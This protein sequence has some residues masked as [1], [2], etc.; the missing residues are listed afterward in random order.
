MFR[1]LPVALLVIGLLLGPAPAQPIAPEKK[2]DKKPDPLPPGTVVAVYESLAEALKRV[3][4]AILLTP[5]Q[6][7]QL[8]DEIDRLKKQNETPKPRVPSKC[9]ITGKIEGNLALLTVRFEFDTEQPGTPVR[10]GFGQGSA[11]G[12]RLGGRT[13]SLVNDTSKA[14]NGFIVE[15]DRAGDHTLDLDLVVPLTPR[16][17]GIGLLVDLPRAAITSLELTLPPNSRDV[18]LAGKSAAEARLNVRDGS[19]RTDS[20]GPLDR[21]DLHWRSTA[22]AATGATLSV[23]SVIDVRVEAKQ[24]LSDAQ[25]TLRVLGGQTR[26]WPLM[27]PPDAEVTVDSTQT[28]RIEKIDPP[29]EGKAPRILRLK[30]ES[31]EPIILRVRSVVPTPLPGA[32]KVPLGP[33]SVPGVASQTGS[34]FVHNNVP[35]YHLEFSSS[36]ELRRRAPTEEENRK[37][38]QLVGVFTYGPTAPSSSWLE[39]E[40]DLVRGQLKVRPAYTLRLA[41]DGDPTP[42]WMVETELTVTPRWAEVDRLLV[43][44]PEGCEF[45]PDASYPLPDRVRAVSYD[46]IARQV[47]FRFQRST[48]AVAPFKVRLTCRIGTEVDLRRIGLT[49]VPLPR[50]AGIIEPESLLRVLVPPRVRVVP[51]D[52]PTG[53]ELMRQ[54]THELVYR[55]PRRPPERV[56]VGWGPYRPEVQVQRV[57]DVTL[58]TNARVRHEL[59]YSV[60]HSEGLIPRQRLRVPA[61]LM[62]EMLVREGEVRSEGEYLSLQLR[63]EGET[64]VVLEYDLPIDSDDLTLP[65][66]TPEQSDRLETRVRLWSEG[67]RLPALVPSGWIE[68]PIEQ[69]V[70]RDRLPVMVL[71]SARPTT[72]LPLALRTEA[73]TARI[74]VERAY[75]RV[76]IGTGGVQDY[77]VR[78]RLSRLVDSFLDLELPGTVATLG[79]QIKLDD[80]GIEPLPLAADRPEM[81]GRLVRLKLAPELVQDGSILEIAYQLSAERQDQTPITTRL[82]LPRLRDEGADFPCRWAILAPENRV[83]LQ[84]E[85]GPQIPRTWV[86]SGWLFAPRMAVSLAEL[87]RWLEESAPNAS[88]ERII[89]SLVLWRGNEDALALTVVPRQTW[90]VACS[91]L[92]VLLG[93]FLLRLNWGR[94]GRNSAW[95]WPVLFALLLVV[96]LV[97]LL[98]PGLASQL[99]FGAQPGLLVLAVLVPLVWLVAERNRRQVVFLANFSRSKSSLSRQPA[100][101]QGSTVDVPPRSLSSVERTGSTEG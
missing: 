56:A 55:S 89:P 60:P 1:T 69:V 90:L 96:S 82:Q 44:I 45:V 3:P 51:A 78:Y 88:T 40:T 9:A 46:P 81:K 38:P 28:D 58:G 83:L 92:V 54:T 13:P 18:R 77:R 98:L 84:P 74:V 87:D 65:L 94:D 66:I 41:D 34:I 80:K 4:R 70:S 49:L 23:E 64:R 25:L 61:N 42:A 63:P 33:F 7:Q 37:D 8:L 2:A 5:E 52:N 97:A 59:I 29:R 86:R 35:G 36:G 21:L 47:L 6:Y 27:L 76:E 72:T 16:P 20:L 10:L 99:A 26:E 15:V 57:V 22:A 68:S 79:L 95:F 67:G 30:S 43:N 19:V 48:E 14:G 24:T 31:A 75:A 50:P 100:E 32:G 17:G 85:T 73:M 53:L 11:T 93:L 39:M 101:M 91:G 12:V 71:R 62:G